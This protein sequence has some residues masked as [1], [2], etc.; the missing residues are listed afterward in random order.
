MPPHWPYVKSAREDIFG[1]NDGKA[2]KGN[3]ETKETNAC[4]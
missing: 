3:K 1:Q 4:L 2:R